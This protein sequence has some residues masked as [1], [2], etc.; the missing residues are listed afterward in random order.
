MGM[1]KKKKKL[2]KEVYMYQNFLTTENALFK[3]IKL[4]NKN[5]MEIKALIEN[6]IVKVTLYIL[7]ASLKR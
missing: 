2:D 4:S 5:I 1:I 7:V 6:I 3:N